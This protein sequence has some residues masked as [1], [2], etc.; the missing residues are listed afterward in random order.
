MNDPFDDMTPGADAYEMDEDDAGQD[1]AALEAAMAEIAALKEQMLR[2]AAD[3]ENGKRRAE[4]EANDARAFAIQKFARDLMGVADNLSRALQHAP[5]DDVD[6]AVKNLVVGL[7]MT[8][9]ALRDAFERN[10]LKK[11]DPVRGEKFDPSFHQAMMEQPAD[12]VAAGGVLQ[13]M[14]TGYELMGRLI[15]PAMVIVA[16]KGSGGSIP[17]P[18]TDEI[19][20]TDAAGAYASPEGPSG[21]AVDTKA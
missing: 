17:S 18:A 1:S 9:K 19:S 11:L 7:D 20:P 13:V 6:P 16:A 5:R 21:E 14:Q 8:E 4:R 15:R 12:D 3:A 2:V 10:G